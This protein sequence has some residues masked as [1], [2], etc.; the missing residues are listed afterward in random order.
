MIPAPATLALLGGGQL[1]RYFVRAAQEL[2]YQVMVLD[3][4]SNS[5]A[6]R[7]ADQHLCTAYDD[8]DAL[9][10]LAADCAAATTEFENVPAETLARLA[11]YMPVRP[12]AQVV[13]VAQDRISEKTFLRENGFP[14]APFAIIRQ[15]ADLNTVDPT[16]FPAILKVSRLGYDGQGQ[17]GVADQNEAIA[18]FRKFQG[19]PCVLE[20]RMPLDV[21]V[22]VVMARNASGEIATYPVAENRHRHGILDIS[23][24]PGTLTEALRQHAETVATALA[25]Q[26]AYTGVLA[27]EF[28][29]CGETLL[30]NEIAPRPHNSGHYTLDACVTDQFEQQVR[31]LCDL[32]LASPAQHSHAVMV[33]VL[34][35]LWFRQPSS[36]PCEPDWRAL[37]RVPN[38]KLHLYGKQHARAGRKMGHFTVVDSD[39]D[40]A[41]KTAL[42]ARQAIG[43]TASR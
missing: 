17:T 42:A 19:E 15:E 14:V 27:V 41:L 31:T 20:K 16:L 43:I 36:A 33:N 32:P 5:P 39:A 1:G 28:F 11:H 13:S 7:I 30:V 34:G 8:E 23:I 26:L 29:I 10:A 37:L 24:A 38:L 40:A 18:E 21:E 12:S 9:K 6:G 4:D 25:D 22:S 3:P 35:D 2:G